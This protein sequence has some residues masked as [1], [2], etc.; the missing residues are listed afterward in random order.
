MAKAKQ[1]A[2]MLGILMGVVVVAM[3][4]MSIAGLAID[5][6]TVVKTSSELIGAEGD[7]SFSFGYYSD[8][9]IGEDGEKLEDITIA[10]DSDNQ[11]SMR[12]A[13]VAFGYI[14]VIA[15]CALAVLYLLKMVLNFGLMR[16]LVGLLGIVTLAAGAVLTGVTASYCANFAGNISIGSIVSNEL[17][18]GT[19]AYLACI[20]TM[21]GGLAAIVGVARK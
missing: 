4:A 17:M 11:E 7:T 8:S 19:G 18:M 6:W 12:T 20:G 5:E 13:M 10:F 21:A 9:V 14:A 16:F 2:G 3:C 15:V 1:K